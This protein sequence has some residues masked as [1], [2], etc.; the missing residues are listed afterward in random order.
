MVQSRDQ[1]SHARRH[2][3]D[4][5]NQLLNCPGTVHVQGN[6]HQ[7]VVALLHHRLQL[8][9][10]GHLH[11]LLAEIVPKGIHHELHCMVGNL[12]KHSIEDFWATLVQFVLQHSATSLIFGDAVDAAHVCIVAEHF[13]QL[14]KFEGTPGR[15]SIVRLC[16]KSWTKHTRI[17]CHTSCSSF[18]RCKS[19]WTTWSSSGHGSARCGKR[20]HLIPAI[21]LSHL[22]R[23]WRD[24]CG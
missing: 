9:R 17:R 8:P 1:A 14:R 4:H 16:F 12:F 3:T 20:H 15:L 23:N 21:R 7:A 19:T 24:R 5:V 2:Q 13:L 22:L 10:A 11:E 18:G 6:I